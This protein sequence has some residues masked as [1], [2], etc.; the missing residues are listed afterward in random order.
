MALIAPVHGYASRGEATRPGPHL[1]FLLA[2]GLIAAAAF[3]AASLLPGGFVLPV[4]CTL[5]FASAAV[6]AL[7]SWRSRGAASPRPSYWDVAGALT[8]IGVC[9]AALLQP[10]QV[11]SLVELSPRRD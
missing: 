10:E 11:V 5:L 8:L 7:L 2:L 4:V 3:L 6:I 9:V 1:V